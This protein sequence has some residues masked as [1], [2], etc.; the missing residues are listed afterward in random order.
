MTWAIKTRKG[1]LARQGEQTWFE[2]KPVGWALFATKAGALNLMEWHHGQIP[3]VIEE[4]E[5]VEVK[6]T[7]K[8]CECDETTDHDCQRFYSDDGSMVR[9]VNMAQYEVDKLSLYCECCQE[10]REDREHE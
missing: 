1:Y 2:D 8:C 3:D 9:F 4:G 6:L 7:V 10:D 5:V